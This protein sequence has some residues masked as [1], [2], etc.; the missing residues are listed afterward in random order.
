ME[1]E[2][3]L[4]DQSVGAGLCRGCHDRRQSKNRADTRVCDD[5]VL[6]QSCIPIPSQRV[7]AFLNIYYEQNLHLCQLW[8]VCVR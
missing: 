6:V 3:F 2:N 8:E 5:G 1:I 7:Q 4:G